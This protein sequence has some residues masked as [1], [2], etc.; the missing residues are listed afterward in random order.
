ML[1]NFELNETQKK[2]VSDSYEYLTV[3]L[4]KKDWKY[5][6]YFAKNYDNLT[7]QKSAVKKAIVLTKKFLGMFIRIKKKIH[8]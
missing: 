4:K 3:H 2:I 6:S 5:F 1:D 7:F 8:G